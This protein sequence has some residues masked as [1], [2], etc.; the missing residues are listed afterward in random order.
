MLSLDV[1]LE[2]QQSTRQR[3]RRDQRHAPRTQVS[4]GK[5]SASTQQQG[6]H[7]QA[8]HVHLAR[9]EQGMA[10]VQAAPDD[11]VASDSLPQAANRGHVVP[12]RISAESFVPQGG[13]GSVE[14]MTNFGSVMI[15]VATGSAVG[16]ADGQ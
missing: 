14:E 7:A 12:R 15:G 8:Q 2:H 10:Q 9:A 4:R 1:V 16:S 11:Q 13:D 5:G 6:E 3:L